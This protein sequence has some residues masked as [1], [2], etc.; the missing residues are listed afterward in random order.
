ML[1]AGDFYAHSKIL[2]HA[3]GIAIGFLYGFIDTHIWTPAESYFLVMSLVLVDFGT[4]ILYAYR[5][6]TYCHQKAREAI[7][8]IGAYTILLFYAFQ[9][10][11]QGGIMPVLTHIVF[12]PM[13]LVTLVSVV[14]NFLK[15]GWI[16]KELALLV[17]HKINSNLK[18]DEKISMP[19]PADR[20]LV[21][22]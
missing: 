11:K 19:E 6:G 17:N 20:E 21:A 1:P 16:K 12:V 4:G 5:T 8:T 22:H 15:L 7:F 18:T 9:F 10:S 2:L 3:I 13:V 14:Q